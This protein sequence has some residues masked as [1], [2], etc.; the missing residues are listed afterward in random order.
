MTTSLTSSPLAADSEP[1]HARPSQETLAAVGSGPDGLASDEVQVRR[2]SFGANVL[3]SRE[4]TGAAALLARQ[5]R[6]P[7][8]YALIVSGALALLLGKIIDGS[9]VLGVVV[10]NALIGFVQEHRARRAIEALSDQVPHTAT[11]VRDGQSRA[12]PAGELVPGDIVLL[13]PG[14]RVAADMRLL[15]AHGLQAIEAALTGESAPAGKQVEP[16]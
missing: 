5:L 10:L 16:V 2:E 3:R 12:L 6:N 15:E 7:L 11:V 1:W 9:V 4:R 14:D 13:Q 8:M